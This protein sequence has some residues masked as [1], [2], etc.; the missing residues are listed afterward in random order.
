MLTGLQ[1]GDET[2]TEKRYFPHKR[3]LR[4]DE[5]HDRTCHKFMNTD[6]VVN[7]LNNLEKDR[8]L[9]KE[10]KIEYKRVN[11]I[12]NDFIRITNRLQANPDDDSLQNIARDMLIMMGEVILND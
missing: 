2:M 11:N 3:W 4:N 7:R 10:L 5:I 9:L 1:R 12:L 8:Q 6:E